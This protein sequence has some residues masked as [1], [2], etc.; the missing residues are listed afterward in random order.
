MISSLAGSK[1]TGQQRGMSGTQ[2]IDKSSSRAYLV[3]RRAVRERCGGQTSQNTG[4][5]HEGGDDEVHIS[6]WQRRSQ[7]LNDL[8][9]VS[10]ALARARW[11]AGCQQ[12]AGAPYCQRINATPAADTD[13]ALQ[14]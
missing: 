5:P 8:Q 11:V 1:T 9:R 3:C 14:G 7:V 6:C 12:S 4:F 13:S 2:L 10:G